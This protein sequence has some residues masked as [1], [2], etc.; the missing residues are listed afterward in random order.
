MVLLGIFLC[1]GLLAT[2][3][4]IL[5]YTCTFYP[6]LNK[7]LPSTH[8]GGRREEGIKEE[9]RGKSAREKERRERKRGTEEKEGGERRGGQGER[10]KGGEIRGEVGG[11]RELY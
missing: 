9:E 1:A 2:D 8:T 7:R 10:E 3:F 5:P 11:G 6:N 4:I